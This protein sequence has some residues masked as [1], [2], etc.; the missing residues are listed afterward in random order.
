[1]EIVC[2]DVETFS[3]NVKVTLGDVQQPSL[4]KIRKHQEA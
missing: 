1:M 4:V 3:G 2:N